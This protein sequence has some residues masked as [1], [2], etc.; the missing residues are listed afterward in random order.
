MLKC[1]CTF[2]LYQ[3][4]VQRTLNWVLSQDS[5]CD[6]SSGSGQSG[7]TTPDPGSRPGR[8]RNDAEN[9]VNVDT[10]MPPPGSTKPVAHTM[11][12]VS[13]TTA[14]DSLWIDKGKYRILLALAIHFHF[15]HN[16]T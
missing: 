7:H 10:T 6:S 16:L 13:I 12:S 2:F 9:K 11:P 1:L 5:K 4:K 8:Q 3:I 15:S 14:L